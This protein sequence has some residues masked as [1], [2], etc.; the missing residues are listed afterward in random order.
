MKSKELKEQVSHI[1]SELSQNDFQLLP[2][3][4]KLVDYLNDSGYRIVKKK[5]EKNRSTTHEEFLKKKDQLNEL[6]DKI[7][8][9]KNPAYSMDD[10]DFHNNFRT[11]SNTLGV[12]EML[13][14]A[15]YYLKHITAVLSYAKNPNTPQAEPLDERFADIINYTQFGF[16]MYKERYDETEDSQ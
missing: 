2:Q 14:W 15:V 13:V 6:A 9:S 10:E 12:D 1:K 16:S 3:F 8:E 11:I 4:D 5:T 7:Q